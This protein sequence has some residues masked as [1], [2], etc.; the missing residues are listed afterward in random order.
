MT[1]ES[2]L[3]TYQK[4]LLHFLENLTCKG[5]FSFRETLCYGIM[6]SGLHVFWIYSHKCYHIR[7][8]RR[9]LYNLK[10]IH[11]HYIWYWSVT[12]DSWLL[13]CMMFNFVF[14]TLRPTLTCISQS[15]FMF[16][17]LSTDLVK[18]YCMFQFTRH[19]L[20]KQQLWWNTTLHFVILLRLRVQ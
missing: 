1:S 13:Q 5:E 17:S 2:Y 12:I 14:G 11:R 18:T 15:C 9:I 10:A 6:G 8:C 20:L 4:L 3:L 16:W 19:R 7:I